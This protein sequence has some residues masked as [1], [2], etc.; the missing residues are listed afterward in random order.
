MVK[1]KCPMP[2]RAMEMP[3]SRKSSASASPTAATDSITAP[4][5]TMPLSETTR[6]LTRPSHN[7]ATTGSTA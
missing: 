2:S 5:T 4:S 3:I 1:T 6:S 7:A